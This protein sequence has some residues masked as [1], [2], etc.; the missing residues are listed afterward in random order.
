M[1]YSNGRFRVVLLIRLDIFSSIGLQNS[2]NK[3][4][5][6]SV[7]LDW[8]TTY[9][10][11]RNSQIFSLVDR[12]LSAQQDEK[13]E[14][15][16]AWDFYFPWKSNSTSSKRD[17][18]PS[19]YKLLRLSY[20]RPRDLV[21]ML[22]ILQQV[23][24]VKK[25]DGGAN[26]LEEDFDSDSFQNRYSEYLMGGIKDQ[27]AFYYTEKDFKFFLRFFAN[28]NGKSSFGYEEYLTA[29]KKFT[30]EILNFHTEI[31]EFVESPDKFLQFL[32]DTN[33][34]CYIEDSPGN[35]PFFRWCYR[36]RSSVNISP[37][38]KNGVRYEMHYGLK[39]ALNLDLKDR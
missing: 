3:L 17:F 35:A 2:T 13:L 26:F 28:F 7:F 8:M 4:L 11:Y 9:P 1:K 10:E 36:E 12:L 30:D 24:I 25:K 23:F 6:N 18:D 39:R 14:L 32:Y 31:P 33:I 5:D 34:I 20:S 21:T 16:K 37:K 22:K 29:Y 19:F 27:L 15:G 38:V